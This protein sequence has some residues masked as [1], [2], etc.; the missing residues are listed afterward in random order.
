MTERKARKK[1]K[2]GS[3]PFIS[4]VFSIT[5]A[6]TVLGLFGWVLLHSNRLGNQIRE[7]VEVQVFLNKGLSKSEINKIQ[8]QIAVKKYILYKEEIPQVNLI[9]K[10]QAAREFIEATGEDFKDFLGDNP[11]RDLL[12]VNLKLGYQSTDS[13]M[14]I[15]SDIEKIAGI[16]EVDYEENLVELI[17]QNVARI[18]FILI[19]IAVFALLVVV[20]L[21]NNTIKLALFSQRF[22]IRS[23][24]LVGATSNFIRKPFLTRSLLYGLIGGVMASI[25]LYSFTVYL[26]SLIDGLRELQDVLGFAI[27]FGSI[28]LIGIIVGYLSS[29]RA[30]R[31]YL[32]MSLDELY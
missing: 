9:T 18:G 16:F 1:K 19:A 26:N 14:Y 4:V 29:R 31:K 8:S 21:I 30:V 22:L 24:Q 25:I 2:L 10:E 32:N 3:Y 13:L 15:K 6:L 28:I 7:N 20:V 27:I 12:S 11:L 17:N 23:M 5:I